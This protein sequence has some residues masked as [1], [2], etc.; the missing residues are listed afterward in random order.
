MPNRNNSGGGNDLRES[1]RPRNQRNQGKGNAAILEE[2]RSQRKEIGQLR[3]Q[4]KGAQ[5][6][7]AGTPP[8]K[9]RDPRWTCPAADCKFADNYAFRLTCLRCST[10]RPHPASGTPTPT[11]PPVPSVST[12]HREAQGNPGLLDGPSAADVLMEENP[13]L[14]MRQ[15]MARAMLAAAKSLPA[16]QES[17]GMIAFYDQQLAALSEEERRGKPLHAQLK[18]ALDRVEAKR[19][20]HETLS[21][22]HA[23]LEEALLAKS[24]AMS[25]AIAALQ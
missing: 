20:H 13:P 10:K 4:L 14:A 8:A 24:A 5:R 11:T 15:S 18:S 7:P 19:K 2:L 23:Q 22:E 16:N 21:A 1:S 17:A 3:Q 6:Q 25:E 12:V 9:G